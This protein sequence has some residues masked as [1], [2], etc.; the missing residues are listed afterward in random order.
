MVFRCFSRRD[1]RR[2]A[3]ARHTCLLRFRRRRVLPAAGSYARRCAPA[4]R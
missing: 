1:C 3:D 4:C 2:H